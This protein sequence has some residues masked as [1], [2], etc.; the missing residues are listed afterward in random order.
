MELSNV[1]LIAIFMTNHRQP[2]STAPSSIMVTN[3]AV[4]RSRDYHLLHPRRRLD[5][6]EVL[7]TV[8]LCTQCGDSVAALH[9]F[10]F[11]PTAEV[12]LS[13]AADGLARRSLSR[14]RESELRQVWLAFALF[15]GGLY[16]SLLVAI[17][18]VTS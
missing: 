11:S 17:A 6:G 16:L 3:S 9:P 12:V 1:L 18:S 10:A 15:C 2:G 14:V 13:V 8:L 4:G 5:D 7:H